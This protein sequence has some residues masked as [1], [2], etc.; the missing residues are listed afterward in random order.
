MVHTFSLLGYVTLNDEKR[1]HWKY[2]TVGRNQNS[3]GQN[4]SSAPSSHY[5][6]AIRGWNNF[7]ST[8]APQDSN[9]VFFGWVERLDVYKM[10]HSV[11]GLSIN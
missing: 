7:M 3:D 4:L 9:L 1:F 6:V 5:S 2:N 11:Y 10:M 8:F